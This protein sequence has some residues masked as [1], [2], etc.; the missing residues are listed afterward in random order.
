MTLREDG[1]FRLDVVARG[2]RGLAV[3]QV[4]G[5][6]DTD[7]EIDLFLLDI[8][9]VEFL[10]KKGNRQGAVRGHRDGV[11]GETLPGDLDRHVGLI[12]EQPVVDGAGGFADLLAALLE[13]VEHRQVAEKSHQRGLG[14]NAFELVDPAHD[15]AVDYRFTVGQVA[16]GVVESR[17]LF[18]DLPHE[19][20]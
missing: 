14:V 17:E 2:Q 6:G 20:A 10:S 19:G 5:R 13:L 1:Y 7:Q 15:A 9:E 4:V 12:V 8:F 16:D 18:G 11:G 3:D